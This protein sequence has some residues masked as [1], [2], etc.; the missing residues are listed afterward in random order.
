MVADMLETLE[1]PSGFPFN[2]TLNFV[3]FARLS[4]MAISYHLCRQRR[5][6]PVK[7]HKYFRLHVENIFLRRPAADFSVNL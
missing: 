1:N 2:I 5:L 7:I 4:C 6:L 3:R